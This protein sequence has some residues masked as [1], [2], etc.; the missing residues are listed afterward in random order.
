MNCSF[1]GK[2]SKEGGTFIHAPDATI[3]GECIAQCVEILFK[4]FTKVAEQ[5]RQLKNVIHII[6]SEMIRKAVP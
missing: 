1:C 3:C 5:N 4:D 6:E 2:P